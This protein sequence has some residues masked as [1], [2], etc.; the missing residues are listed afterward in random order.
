MDS[1]QG[2]AAVLAPPVGVLVFW[3]G[4]Y[5]AASR[6][7]GRLPDGAAGHTL[8]F[9]LFFGAP[10]AYAAAALVG[11]P[12]YRFLR[13]RNSLTAPAAIVTGAVAGALLA[14][15]VVGMS[16]GLQ[17]SDTAFMLA[18]A[19]LGAVSGSAAA[20]TFVLLG[21]LGQDRQATS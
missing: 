19:V 6:Q 16:G 4:G 8:F 20:G 5:L 21:G 15:L 10:L 12:V 2:L 11:V 1:R 14:T 17:R 13:A 3:L 9:F 18:V 7:F